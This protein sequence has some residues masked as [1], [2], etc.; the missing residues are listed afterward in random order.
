MMVRNQ[1]VLN[2]FSVKSKLMLILLAVSLG[3]TLVIGYLSWRSARDTLM[4]QAFNHLTSLRESKA[5]QI[6][7]AFES[8]YND[9]VIL[10]QADAVISAMVRFNKAYKQ[11]DNEFIAATWEQAVDRY[12]REAFFPRLTQ[13]APSASALAFH[14]PVGQ[15]SYY[16]QYH[17]IA[18]N[19]HPIG[20]KWRLEDAGD[21]SAYS[22]F[23]QRYHPD[24]RE[25]VER[26]GYYDLFLIDFDTQD[27]VYTIMKE[28]DF[29]TSLDDGPY[30]NSGLARVVE[31]VRKHPQAGDIKVVDFTHYTPSHGVPAAFFAT[32]VL[33]AYA[34]LHIAG[35]DWSIVTRIDPEIAKLFDSDG[36]GKG[37][38]W[39]GE[40]GW[41]A[42]PVELVKARSYGYARY[43][44]PQVL[45]DVVFKAKLKARYTQKQGI[46]FY[47]WTPEWIH[48][49]YDL[50]RLNE[51]PFNGY[52]MASQASD[53]LYNPEGCWSMV[54]PSEDQDWLRK[55]RVTCA[56]PKSQ[57]YVAFA[58]TLTQRLPEVAQF[59]QQVTLDP[60]EIAKWIRQIGEQ[61]RNPADVAREWVRRH[62][63]LIEQW[64]VDVRM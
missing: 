40:P 47:S 27:I 7:T 15:A 17:Y 13:H 44:E 39:P 20:H 34:P 16:L 32:P 23:H 30:A 41:G 37:E 46:L 24:L 1:I 28:V 4:K 2:R 10:T 25:L 18:S 52:A 58:S 12:Y 6:E 3:S 62:P 64:L 9:M 11:L 61:Q 54:F 8:L 50:R 48:S 59:L 35:F 26:S 31:K 38:F 14:V 33:N 36:D 55:S 56:W 49:V 60:A 21:G 51:P 53:A 63:D 57:M 5:Y 29:A 43:F 45:D 19:P 22:Q 42:T